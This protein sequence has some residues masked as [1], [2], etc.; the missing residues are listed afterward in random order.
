MELANEVARSPDR[1][2]STGSARLLRALHLPV[3]AGVLFTLSRTVAI[4]FC[5]LRSLSALICVTPSLAA[6]LGATLLPA[7]HRHRHEQHHK[8]DRARDR[9]HG[10][11]ATNREHKASAGHSTPSRTCRE[12]T[13][14]ASGP[15]RV[16]QEARWLRPD[17]RTPE[18]VACAFHATEQQSA[19]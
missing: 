7:P 13:R 4:V 6:P 19:V 14:H 9:D 5:P 16:A 15:A 18:R 2:P 8:H 12:H 17:G 1:V 11:A 10:D 3:W